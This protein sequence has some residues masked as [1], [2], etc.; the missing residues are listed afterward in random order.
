[1]NK[2]QRRAAK[3]KAH[4][5]RHQADRQRRRQPDRE[6]GRGVGR[7]LRRVGDR[8]PPRAGGEQMPT[9]RLRV[10]GVS[11]APGIDSPGLTSSLAIEEMMVGL[12]NEVLGQVRAQSNR[13]PTLIF[14]AAAPG[15]CNLSSERR[16][17]CWRNVPSTGVR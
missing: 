7:P 6:L 4:E 17:S 1:M 8:D 15:T 5:R 13:S 9:R 2:T 12:V 16:T 14:A 11:H 3:Q 10:P